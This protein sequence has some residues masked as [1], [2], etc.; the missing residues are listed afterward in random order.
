MAGGKELHF[1]DR[2]TGVDWRDPD[3]SLLH[4]HFSD[5]AGLRGEATPVTLYWT[6]AHYRVLRYNP[7]MRFILLFRDP[8]ARA[9]SHWRMNIT[10]SLDT[11]AFA[12]AIRDGRTRVLDDPIQSGLA[13]HSSYIERGYYGRQVSLLASLF[14]LSNMLFL[15][16][17]DLLAEPNIVLNRVAAFLRIAPFE[18]VAPVL[19]NVSEDTQG[20]SM[21]DEDRAYL[22]EIF[23]SDLD[24]L[25]QLT[26]IELPAETPA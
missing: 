18:P 1:F 14:P 3:Y 21:S 2:E 26:G 5:R 11:L 15:R 9:F 22:T 16:Q 6:P 10:R 7:D 17:T 20:H 8:V 13:R 24:R 23:T 4:S 25:K 12:Q 19:L